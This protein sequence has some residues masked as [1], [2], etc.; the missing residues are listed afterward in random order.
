MRKRVALPLLFSLL[1]GAS[2]L[3]ERFSREKPLPED[4]AIAEIIE[5]ASALLAATYPSSGREFALRGAH[6]KA[7]GCVKAVFTVDFDLPDAF[8]VGSFVS[9][10]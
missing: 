2:F 3:A 7:S 8:R 10:R 9:S 6:A 4:Q 5:R 1:V